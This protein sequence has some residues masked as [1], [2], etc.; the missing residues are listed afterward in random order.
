LGFLGLTV[1]ALWLLGRTRFS[2]RLVAI[3]ENKELAGAV[4]VNAF[5]EKLVTFVVFGVISGVAGVLLAYYLKYI[6]PSTFD[7]MNSVNI[8]LAVLLGGVGAWTGPV[9]GSV[10]FAALPTALGLDPV[11]TRLV[12]GVLLVAIISLSPGGVCGAL[13]RGYLEVV[14]R[15]ADRG[16]DGANGGAVKP[17]PEPSRPDDPH[18]QVT[19]APPRQAPVGGKL[20]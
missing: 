1:V 3:R 17:P 7:A 14:A 20:R 4:G 19:I 11:Q 9:V 13:K 2:T 16:S 8:Q 15:L 10:V 12:Y 6:A 18:E 5:R